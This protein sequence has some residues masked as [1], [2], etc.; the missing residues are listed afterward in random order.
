MQFYSRL[1]NKKEDMEWIICVNRG[2]G[3]YIFLNV[4]KF[5][6]SGVWGFCSLSGI[7]LK[8]YRSPIV[9]NIQGKAL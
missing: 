2:M 7:D 3:V 4:G 8:C 6:L 5:Y 1:K 9:Q